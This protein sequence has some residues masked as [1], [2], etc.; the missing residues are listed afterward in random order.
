MVVCGRTLP[1]SEL[2]SRET[3]TEQLRLQR[4]DLSVQRYLRD[5]RSAAV[6][7]VRL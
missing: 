4:L 6:V 2:P 5:L 3:V 7:D 1:K